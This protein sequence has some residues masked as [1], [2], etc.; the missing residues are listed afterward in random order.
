M[1]KIKCFLGL[2]VASA[3]STRNWRG[4][5]RSPCEHCGTDFI[6]KREK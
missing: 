4:I 2:H 5:H 3:T 6:T 1:R